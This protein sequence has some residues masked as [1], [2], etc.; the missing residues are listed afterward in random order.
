MSLTC[1]WMLGADRLSA[2]ASCEIVLGSCATMLTICSLVPFG[3]SFR[4]VI[5]AHGS[6]YPPGKLETH[7]QGKRKPFCSLTVIRHLF[8]DQVLGRIL[9]AQNPLT[10]SPHLSS[11]GGAESWCFV[12]AR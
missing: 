10:I 3:N 8:T 6:V 4:F 2:W 11:K 7:S 9:K 5:S 1:V 12:D